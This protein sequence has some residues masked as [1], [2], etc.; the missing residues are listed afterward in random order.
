MNTL[1][2]NGTHKIESAGVIGTPPAPT[3]VTRIK[4]KQRMTAAERIAI[5]TGAETDPITFDFM[6]LLS[7]ATYIDLSLAD[8]ING[9][10]YLEAQGYIATGRA[11]EILNTPITT[12]EEY[13]A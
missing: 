10:N 12:D 4:F 3:N 11:N 1:F 13:R 5:R 6:D 2:D 9:V 7:E 8:T